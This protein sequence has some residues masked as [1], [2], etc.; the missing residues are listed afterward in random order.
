MLLL[1]LNL[2]DESSIRFTLDPVFLDYLE[3]HRRLS[4]RARRLPDDS[5]TAAT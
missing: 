4:V 3:G 1:E 2:A 5:I